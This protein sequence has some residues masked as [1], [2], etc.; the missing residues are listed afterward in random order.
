MR[1]WTSHLPLIKRVGHRLLIAADLN[2]TRLYVA[3]NFLAPGAFYVCCDGDT[4]WPFIT[5]FFSVAYT[6]DTMYLVT[7]KVV[8][9]MELQQVVD[10]HGLI[11]A[12]GIR[13]G[14]VEPQKY[15]MHMRLPYHAYRGLFESLPHRILANS[16]VLARYSEK[17]GPTLSLSS[18]GLTSGFR[19]L[20]R[21]HDPLAACLMD[22][23]GLDK[24][25]HAIQELMCQRVFRLAC[26]Y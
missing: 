7:N 14:L 19:H 21:G 16:D 18:C 4:S 6:S 11:I 15:P 24:I 9:S 10:A 13:N 2:F 17:C 25:Q 26:G 12:A 22:H 20:W 23:R 3:K 1:I 5:Q 8:F